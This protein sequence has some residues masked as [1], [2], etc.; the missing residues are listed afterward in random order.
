MLAR[1]PARFRAHFRQQFVGYLAVFIALGGTGY[2][3]SKIGS[4][5]I[6]DNSLLSADL[7]NGAGVKGEDVVDNSLTNVD[8]KNGAGVKGEDVVDN[9][10]GGA[11]IADN[12]L[13]GADIADNS[14]GGADIAESNLSRVPSAL[15]GGLG[16]SSD[17]AVRENC[18]PE[19]NTFV[20]C[21]F[22]GLDLPTPAR[23]FVTG[24]INAVSE[25]A[26]STAT[27]AGTC[28]LGTTSGNVPFTSFTL[29]VGNHYDRASVSGITGVFPAGQHSF[30]IDCNETA[31]PIMYNNARVTAVAI[32]DG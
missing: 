12:S 31:F 23:V 28:L 8:L 13:G 26:S 32:S 2:A 10:L 19:S 15:V 14:L 3:A 1:L 17:P 22:I 4:A 24:S 16:R 7:K 27:G 25:S 9:S 20:N 21:A 29:S 11:D 30:G 6:A 5:G 18:D